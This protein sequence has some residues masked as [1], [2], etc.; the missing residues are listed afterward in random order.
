MNPN[1]S[2]CEL[3]PLTC[4]MMKRCGGIQKTA[5]FFADAD[6]KREA[7]KVKIS[8]KKKD[9]VLDLN[10]LINHGAVSDVLEARID[11]LRKAFDTII[12][13]RP[14]I[15]SILEDAESIVLKL[16]RIYNA[17]KAAHEKKLK[18]EDEAALAEC[19]DESFMPERSND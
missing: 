8:N 4:Q 17:Q 15:P 16:Q 6:K 18:E 9:L 3:P 14:L 1:C 13:R 19:A 2:F 10:C 11:A 5:Q 12:S 7:I